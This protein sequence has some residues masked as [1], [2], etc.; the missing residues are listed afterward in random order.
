MELS[1]RKNSFG[2]LKWRKVMDAIAFK[3]LENIEN[4]GKFG[5]VRVFETEYDAEKA[6]KCL[7]GGILVCAD[8]YYNGVFLEYGNGKKE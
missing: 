7:L 8:G 2:K 4:L 3:T 5:Y 6:L 1:F